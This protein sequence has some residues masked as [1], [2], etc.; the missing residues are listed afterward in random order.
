MQEPYDLMSHQYR[1]CCKVDLTN[2]SCDCGEF[3]AE[4]LSYAH[5]FATCANVSLDLIKFVDHIF[6]LDTMMNIYN[7][8]FQPIGDVAH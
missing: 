5:A 2:Q 4:K 7:N 3:Q 1:Q 6:Q 8:E